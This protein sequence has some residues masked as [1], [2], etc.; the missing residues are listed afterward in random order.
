MDINDIRRAMANTLA[1]AV[2]HGLHEERS[3]HPATEY[4]HLTDM[5]RRMEA[6]DFSIGKAN[7]WLG[8]AQGVVLARGKGQ[9]LLSNIKAINAPP[10]TVLDNEFGENKSAVK[11]PADFPNTTCPNTRQPCTRGCFDLHGILGVVC[12]MNQPR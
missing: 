9:I 10:G 6:P 12:T 2:R 8:Y 11:S 7:R 1:L 4:G 3:D 5:M